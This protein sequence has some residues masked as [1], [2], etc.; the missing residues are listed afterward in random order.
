MRLSDQKLLVPRTQITGLQG[1][2]APSRTGKGE[3]RGETEDEYSRCCSQEA[4]L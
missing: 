3:G 1:G 4:W 2:S